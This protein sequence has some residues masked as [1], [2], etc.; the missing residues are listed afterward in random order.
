MVTHIHILQSYRTCLIQDSKISALQQES[1]HILLD[2]VQKST[3]GIKS[4]N[5][6]FLKIKMRSVCQRIYKV[7]V[8]NLKEEKKKKRKSMQLNG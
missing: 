4:H 1:L 2:A 3:H 6:T 8:F 5:V 7:S